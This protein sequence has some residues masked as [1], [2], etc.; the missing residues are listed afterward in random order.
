[1]SLQCSSHVL[2]YHFV[3]CIPMPCYVRYCSCQPVFSTSYC[4]LRLVRVNGD[5]LLT[6][7]FMVTYS[8]HESV[9]L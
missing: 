4:L 3:F 9:W 8:C 5:M 2:V 6:L 7:P 1:M